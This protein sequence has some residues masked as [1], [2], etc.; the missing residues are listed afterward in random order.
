[1]T[2]LNKTALIIFI[3]ILFIFA[4]GFK[5]EKGIKQFSADYSGIKWQEI[6]AFSN[7]FS[8][9]NIN[10]KFPDKLWWIKFNDPVLDN[11][12][13]QALS[14]NQDIKLALA[15]IEQAQANEKYVFSNELPQLNLYSFYSRTFNSNPPTNSV[16]PQSSR[17]INLVAVPI[18]AQYEI[19]YLRKNHLN[20]LS[21]KKQTESAFYDYQ[22]T[23]I[24]LMS[25]VATD[26]FN[27]IKTDK[28]ICLQCELL[29]NSQEILKRKELQFN[30][31]IAALDDVLSAKQSVSEIIS[32]IEEQK[33][34]QSL[35]VHRL[36]IF[37]GIPPV[38]QS[39]F[40]RSDID[41]INLPSVYFSGNPSE[42]LFRRPDILASE[43][44]LDSS[45]IDVS[46]ARRQLFP[47]IKILGGFSYL[48][49][50][51]PILLNGNN[52]LLF[53]TPFLS[54]PIYDGGKRQA[55]LKI[56]KA[57]YKQAVT[58]YEKTVLTAFKEVEDSLSAVTADIKN[59]NESKRYLIY[60]EEK[61]NI[62]QSR[63]NEG[64]VSCIEVLLS[65]QELLNNKQTEVSKKTQVII[66]NISLYKAL[67][68]GF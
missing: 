5:A 20:T 6:T 32:N 23:Q 14:S 1:M 54:E 61:Q 59:Y 39:C 12:I 18:L 17:N 29:K 13:N 49:S 41:C 44:S 10:E 46:V 43:K 56:K 8:C 26:Y 25:N 21:A 63:Y 47:S 16:P 33:Q 27:L 48:Y 7:S 53:A 30:Q 11:Y 38:E 28:I 65:K 31:G 36:C 55:N 42:L 37:L 67:G 45:G 52:L 64:I 15:R 34:L 4:N 3:I 22:T 40:S 62:F 35:F 60:S 9:L 2:I 57:V 19:D 68:G 50:N 51:L 66:D 58:N 24:I